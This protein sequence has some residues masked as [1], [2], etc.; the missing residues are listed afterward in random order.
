MLMRVPHGFVDPCLA[1]RDQIQGTPLRRGTRLVA[2]A[3]RSNRLTELRT[4][5]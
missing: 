5:I 1:L 2:S 3:A 4:H